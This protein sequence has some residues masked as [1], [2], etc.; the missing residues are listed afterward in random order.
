M[1]PFVARPGYGGPSAQMVPMR[2]GQ[3]PQGMQFMPS[4]GIMFA[5][6]P[7]MHGSPGMQS[8]PGSHPPQMYHPAMMQH[9]GPGM[10][11]M[12]MGGPGPPRAPADGHMPGASVHSSPE[13]RSRA[14]SGQQHFQGHQQHQHQHQHRQ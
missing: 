4:G 10:P 11:L 8:N 5:P 12:P 6:P 9:G 7:A 3:V 2:P 13:Q 1:M 14:P